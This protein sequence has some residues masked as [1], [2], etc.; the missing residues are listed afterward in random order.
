LDA[1]PE[2]ALEPI[3]TSRVI[4]DYGRGCTDG[5]AANYDPVVALSDGSCVYDCGTLTNNARGADAVC[6][7]H[8]NENGLTGWGPPWLTTAATLVVQGLLLS[9]TNNSLV[10][11]GRRSITSPSASYLFHGNADDAVGNKHGIV[12]GNAILVPDRFGDAESAFQFGATADYITVAS[13][14]ADKLSDFTIFVWLKPSDLGDDGDLH[15]FLHNGNM[16]EGRNQ[17]GPTMYVGKNVD[18]LQMA[19]LCRDCVAKTKSCGGCVTA[20]LCRPGICEFWICDGGT[21]DCDWK[22]AG[23]TTESP[24]IYTATSMADG[25]R[26]QGVADDFFE[27]NAYVLVVWVSRG[28]FWTFY[29]NGAPVSGHAGLGRLQH[30]PELEIGRAN[31]NYFSG[32][33]DDVAFYQHALSDDDVGALYAAEQPSP[34]VQLS[35][36]DARPELNN[37]SVTLR[38]VRTEGNEAFGG[39]GKELG[40]TLSLMAST[41]SLESVELVGNTQR[42]FGAGAIYSAGSNTTAIFSLFEQ[43][44]NSGVGA[45]VIAASSAS[46]VV[47]SHSQFRG[48][49]VAYQMGLGVPV[50]NAA[51]RLQPRASCIEVDASDLAAHHS[52]F[53]RNFG[54]DVILATG[55]SSVNLTHTIFK[56]NEGGMYTHPYK[57]CTDKV[58]NEATQTTCAKPYRHMPSPETGP[59][60]IKQWET[61]KVFW[62]G[63]VYK[64]G[65]IALWEGSV[66]NI[67]SCSMQNNA[68]S[69]AAGGIFVS[70]VGSV[71]TLD[72]VD[73]RGNDAA[74]DS[75]AAGAIFAENH[76]HV[77]GTH[78]VL[79]ENTAAASVAAGAIYAGVHTKVTLT[80]SQFHANYAKETPGSIFGAGALLADRASV[81]LTRTTL[82]DNY[83]ADGGT[84][85]AANYADAL[86]VMHQEKIFIGE[87]TFEPLDPGTK[88]V[89][90]NPQIFSG[91]IQGS[92]QQYPCAQG[93]LCTYKN[94][95]LSCS[96]CPD[97]THSSDGIFCELCPPGSGPNSDQTYCEPCSGSNMYSPFGNCLECLGQH[98]VSADRKRCAACPLGLGPANEQRTHCSTCEGNT[99]SKLGVCEPCP[100]GKVGDGDGISCSDCPPN[101]EPSAV[102][103][104]CRCQEGYYNSSFGMVQCQPSSMPAPQ[105]GFMCQPC[106]PC[107]DCQTSLSTFTRA[108]VQ[109]GYKLGVAATRTYRGVEIGNVNS[110]KVFHKCSHGQSITHFPRNALAP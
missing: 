90:I 49:A 39:G 1:D 71:A 57:T 31:E 22:S 19:N 54:G 3:H 67:V 30:Q 93:S 8:K 91:I 55:V 51:P 20:N 103:L 85:T 72:H 76:S 88:T 26:Q 101:A 100:A 94:F 79:A 108:L 24:L 52:V 78:C 87:S 33:I 102:A 81:S 2:S 86:Y 110:N 80:D 17:L 48:N 47:V 14:F 68:V 73:L 84:L 15:G 35:Q 65:T 61:W 66:A 106:G 11:H 64:G 95:S 6:Y 69:S 32:T 63:S 92:C 44:L 9:F 46:R 13:P 28:N 50:R 75:A 82:V 104:M 40:A 12:I 41:A 99:V 98:V 58:H 56:Q 42:G 97:G 60:I 89:A 4:P 62:E 43:N 107:L 109:P 83:R 27:K 70:G 59:A 21:N 96:P 10:R 29:K 77:Y 36:F 7:A 25:T 38:H 23:N 16:D 105:D 18:A 34:N 74:C 37:Q 5:A 45:G 53:E